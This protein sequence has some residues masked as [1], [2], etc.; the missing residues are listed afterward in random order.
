MALDHE[1]MRQWR[2]GLAAVKLGYSGSRVSSPRSSAGWPCS[3][4][5]PRARKGARHD[6][7]DDV[8][9]RE[10]LALHGSDGALGAAL[11]ILR[12][13]EWR[14]TERQGHWDRECP[15][16][17]ASEMYSGGKHKSGCRLARLLGK[18]EG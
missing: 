2:E 15:V 9:L 18:N 1:A 14:P 5:M 10:T 7:R 13:M 4:G 12:E 17:G 11:K 6:R 16:C 3:N 8:Q